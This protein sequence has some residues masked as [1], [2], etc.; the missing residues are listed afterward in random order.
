MR[1]HA[2]ARPMNSW[3]MQFFRQLSHAGPGESGL[4][5][6]QAHLGADGEPD[7]HAILQAALR[8]ALVDSERAY[9]D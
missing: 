3:E 5:G 9:S 2:Q 1:E 8:R 7:R 6:L 4:A